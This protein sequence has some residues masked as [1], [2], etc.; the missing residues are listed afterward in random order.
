MSGTVVF[1]CDQFGTPAWANGDFQSKAFDNPLG[2]V[3]V[4]QRGTSIDTAAHGG[5]FGVGLRLIDALQPLAWAG[6]W[7]FAK[8]SL[9]EFISLMPMPEAAPPPLFRT[10]REIGPQAISL[11]VPADRQEV[12]VV[13]YG[14][15]L[16]ASLIKMPCAD[17]K[18]ALCRPCDGER[19]NAECGSVSASP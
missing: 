11:H 17:D 10:G 5:D 4:S 13:L 3:G 2:P 1:V 8:H 18:D 6:N 12:L 9:S 14:E 7:P 15:R 16:E 19:A